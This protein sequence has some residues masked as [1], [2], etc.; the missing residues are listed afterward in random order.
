MNLKAFK[1]RIYP[2]EEQKELIHQHFGCVRWIY[3]YALNKKIT[4]F[5]T[6]KKSL[7]RFEIQA[8]IPLLKKDEATA[9]LKDV[10]SQ[11]LQASL[12][13]LDKAYTRF[14]RE[15][16]GFPKF[17]SKHDNRQSFQVPQHAKVDFDTSKLSL[18]KFKSGILLICSFYSK[19]LIFIV[20]I[21][22]FPLKNI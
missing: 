12:E 13:N 19:V 22:Y 7:S 4:V 17:K 3:N 18:P 1:Y 2:T 16:K 6:E 11:S 20:K 10:N 21:L 9:W 8:D 15:K 5:Q 14:F